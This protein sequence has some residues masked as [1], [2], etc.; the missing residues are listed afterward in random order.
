MYDNFP[1]F[2][3]IA[4]SAEKNRG[5]SGS[6]GKLDQTIRWDICVAL[7]SYIAWQ[8]II[9]YAWNFPQN[10]DLIIIYITWNLDYI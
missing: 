7:Y 3:G 6:L 2:R 5:R 1:K 9:I 8:L 10:V 4:E